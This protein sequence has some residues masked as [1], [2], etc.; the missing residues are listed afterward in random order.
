MAGFE[1]ANFENHPSIA[2]EFV[3]FLATNTGIEGM[4]V[5][6]EE[7]TALKSKLKDTEKQA[8]LAFGKADEAS[9]VADVVQKATETLSKQVDRLVAKVSEKR[10]KLARGLAQTFVSASVVCPR[11]SP[12]SLPCS[13]PLTSRGSVA[14]L[15]E[16]FG[17]HL[18]VNDLR[19]EKEIKRFSRQRRAF[20][21]GSNSLEWNLSFS[22]R[23]WSV[24]CVAQSLPLDVFTSK[25]HCRMQIV[26]S[27]PKDWVTHSKSC[28][29][30]LGAGTTSGMSTILAALAE[31]VPTV[32]FAPSF[33]TR[34]RRGRALH[35]HTVGGATTCHGRLSTRDWDCTG[36]PQAVPR[37]LGDI[38]DHSML[39]DVCS[40]EPSF[41]HLMPED[42][43][44]VARPLLPVGFPTH[45]THAKWGSRELTPKEVALCLD[46]PLW[47]VSHPVL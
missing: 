31:G 14:R 8:T 45:A 46:A 43:L 17:T 38:L 5:L 44:P 19:V 35:H 1:D 18:S 40:R 32:M 13:T 23:D 30:L 3:K 47:I 39:P 28:D 27:P 9:S 12:S 2:S 33:N 26:L 4:A 36:L 34:I 21:F 25:V 41:P 15:A 42:F 37:Q 6:Q 16:E 11:P 10:G 20:V 24:I 22:P 29:V 7:V